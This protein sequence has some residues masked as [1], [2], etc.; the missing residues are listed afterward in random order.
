MVPEHVVWIPA[1]HRDLTAG[2]AQVHVVAATV[3]EI[4]A[5]LEGRFPGLAARLTHDN[6]LRA[7]IVVA[8][9]GEVSSRGLRQRLSRASEV[10]FVPAIAGGQIGSGQR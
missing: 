5:A 4:V 8:V 10:H 2:Q 6:A 3:G 7:G 9:N 1:V